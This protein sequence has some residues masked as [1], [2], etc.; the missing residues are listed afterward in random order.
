MWHRGIEQPCRVNLNSKTISSG[1]RRGGVDGEAGRD[2]FGSVKGNENDAGIGIP[3]YRIAHFVSEQNK[4][5]QNELVFVILIFVCMNVINNDMGNHSLPRLALPRLASVVEI[6]IDFN[7]I[8]SLSDK[9]EGKSGDIVVLDADNKVKDRR[10]YTDVDDDEVVV[11]ESKND[12]ER[13]LFS[14]LT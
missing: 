12:D 5:T 10:M 6:A 1:R 2:L 4:S 3:H 7:A 13:K 11:V 14:R 8:P 9:R